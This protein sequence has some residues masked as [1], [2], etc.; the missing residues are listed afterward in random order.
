MA[1]QPHYRLDDPNGARGHHDRPHDLA[2]AVTDRFKEV[3]DDVRERVGQVAEQ[4]LQY[5]EMAQ[6]AVRQFK[7]F[8]QKSLKEQP[9]TTVASFVLVGFVLGAMWKK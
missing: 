1:R 5:A 2:D 8:V 4:A 9:M 3:T 7:P 6:D